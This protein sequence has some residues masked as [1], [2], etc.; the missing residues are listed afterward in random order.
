MPDTGYQSLGTP[1][2]YLT[3][4]YQRSRPQLLSESHV[5]CLQAIPWGASVAIIMIKGL[6]HVHSTAKK[7]LRYSCLPYRHFKVKP[8][9]INGYKIEGYSHFGFDKRTNMHNILRTFPSTSVRSLCELLGEDSPPSCMPRFVPSVVDV[10]HL[11]PT[12]VAA[13]DD[14]TCDFDI[15]PNLQNAVGITTAEVMP[16]RQE[17][18]CES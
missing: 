13:Q 14:N 2:D 8:G 3:L 5:S 6:L 11:L 1:S 18:L 16:P 12:A 10:A 4:Y 9:I 7:F 15:F 17:R